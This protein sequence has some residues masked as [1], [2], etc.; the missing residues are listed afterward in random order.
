VQM[1]AVRQVGEQAGHAPSVAEFPQPQA[2]PADPQ[3]SWPISAA[4]SSTQM[5]GTAE[6][7][8]APQQTTEAAPIELAAAP[9][10][11]ET[12]LPA[13][14]AAPVQ[15]EQPFEPELVSA[16]LETTPQELAHARAEA[17][18]SVDETSSAPAPED[19]VNEAERVHQAVERVFDRFRPLL[20]AAIVR[21]LVRRD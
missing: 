7:E 16:P 14:E 9:A 18:A 1:Q 4:D 20:I 12:E 3:S 10:P 2:E 5:W 17:E 6:V 21:E 11:L 8:S 15:Q 19:G 13:A